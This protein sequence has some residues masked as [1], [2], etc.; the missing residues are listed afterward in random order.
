MCWSSSHRKCS[1]LVFIQLQ[2]ESGRFG[3]Y[4]PGQRPSTRVNTGAG[5]RFA[6]YDALIDGGHRQREGPIAAP[7]LDSKWNSIAEFR[8]RCIAASISGN[9]KLF[10]G[11]RG[12]PMP[13]RRAWLS[14]T[15]SKRDC[16][17][18]VKVEEERVGSGTFVVTRSLLEHFH[19]GDS[20]S[21]AAKAP[22]RRPKAL[23]PQAALPASPQPIVRPSSTEADQALRCAR[24]LF[25]RQLSAF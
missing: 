3:A 13:G 1:S 6:Q 2:I 16:P 8:L 5:R 11:N 23:P 7:T 24:R 19:T 20:M 9:Y 18:V 10:V 22:R 12:S 17:V 21:K 15:C 4:F 25:G 14:M